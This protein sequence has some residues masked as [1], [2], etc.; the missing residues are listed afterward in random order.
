MQRVVKG[1]LVLGA[2]CLALATMAAVRS[3]QAHPGGRAPA[4]AGGPTPPQ[5]QQAYALARQEFGLLSG[6]GWAQAWG[7]WTAS[8]QQAVPQAEFVHV[9]TACR[10]AMGQLYAIDGSSVTDS[11]TVRV[12]WHRAGT[13]GMNESYLERLTRARQNHLLAPLRTAVTGE[14]AANGP[15]LEVP[16]P[17]GP[18]SVSVLL[19]A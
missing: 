8:A 9:N 14:S 15:T 17:E 1:W 3:G 4:G 5:P 7:L 18:A 12:T 19:V 16:S 13:T 2:A 11:T 6:G 10:P